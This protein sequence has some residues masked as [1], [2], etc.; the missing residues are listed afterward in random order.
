MKISERVIQRLILYRKILQNLSAD[1]VSKIY[2][3]TLG[4][5]VDSTPAQVR[6]DIMNI[7]YKGTPAHGYDITL[8][9][10]S[11]SD[12][13]DSPLTRNV[14][15]IGLGNL[16]KAILDYCQER[17]SKLNIIDAFD[18]DPSKIN[19]DINGC[20]S[21]HINE[22][23]SKIKEDKIELAILSVPKSEAQAIA[24]RLIRAGIKGILNYSP[25]ELRLPEYVYVENRDML[26]ALEKVAYFA[27]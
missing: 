16:G 17:N 14:C 12:F 7:G 10:S 2:S 26:L 3:H 5:F 23:E 1:G 25:I 4:D 27:K 8:L 13:I 21:Y 20:H 19:I 9:I 18:K 24:E 11:I 22:L 15:I 6:R